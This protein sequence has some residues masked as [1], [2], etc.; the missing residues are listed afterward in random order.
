MNPNVLDVDMTPIIAAY[1][2]AQKEHHHMSNSISDDEY[3][4]RAQARFGA[5]A[6]PMAILP[7]ALDRPLARP[8]RPT[9]KPAA[10][11]AASPTQS[12]A[13]PQKAQPMPTTARRAIGKPDDD[14][15]TDTKP[16][17]REQLIDQLRKLIADAQKQL[18]ELTKGPATGAR[19]AARLPAHEADELKRRMGLAA[20]PSGVVREGRSLVFHVHGGE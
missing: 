16:P 15:D 11:R 13:A 6:G 9:T 10:S 19:R 1:R 14:T 3:Q 7:G 20:A 4:R 18:D 12:A 17:T 5:G 8:W 2:A